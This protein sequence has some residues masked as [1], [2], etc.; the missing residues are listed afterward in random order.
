MPGAVHTWSRGGLFALGFAGALCAAIMVAE[1]HLRLWLPPDVREYF[2]DETAQDGIFR[3]D[4]LI[5]V[6]YRNYR[7]FA[8]DNAQR[9]AALGPLDDSTPTWLFFGNSFV[10]APGMLADTARAAM[11]DRRIFNL[12]RNEHL[13]L[14]VAQARWLIAAG[15]RPERVFFVLLPH[16]LWHIG[17]RP[18]AFIAVNARGAMGARLRLPDAPWDGPIRS[19]RLAAVAWARIGWA[20]GDPAFKPRM[21]A[22]RPSRRVAED[23]DRL[24]AVLGEIG[25]RHSIPVT[26]ITLPNREQ[27]YGQ[28]PF[29]FQ[30]AIDDLARRHGL[31]HYDARE[32]FVSAANK[33]M[34][35]EPDAHFS[36]YGN[37][38]LLAGLV[39]HLAALETRSAQR[40]RQP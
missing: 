13:S 21:V 15:L 39:A 27:I 1:L 7:A 28:S 34:L 9:L 5:G 36:P 19:S 4:P 16:D 38:L 14:R 31:D 32:P 18:L 3:P 25:Q 10:Q 35:F 29:G 40:G 23:L 26:V 11:P 22:E 2:G 30:A 24:F 6:D 8:D 12:A 20:A 17:K 33:A 37:R